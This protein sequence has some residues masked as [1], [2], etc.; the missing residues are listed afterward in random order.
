MNE[1]RGRLHPGIGAALAAAIFFGLS[2]PAA[3]VLL[4]GLSPWML[5][6][7]LYL[8]VGCRTGRLAARPGPIQCPTHSK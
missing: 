3:K 4:G 1:V 6:G 5:A 2:T 7:L 8:G